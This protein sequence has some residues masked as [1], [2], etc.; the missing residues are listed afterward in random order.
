MPD[1]AGGTYPGEFLFTF[2]VSYM[3]LSTSMIWFRRAKD[4]CDSP[5]RCGGIWE[6]GRKCLVPGG[7]YHI[8][9]SPSFSEITTCTYTFKHSLFN[10]PRIAEIDHRFLKISL[11]CHHVAYQLSV[12][13]PAGGETPPSPVHVLFNTR[14]GIPLPSLLFHSVPIFW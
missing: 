11:C 12:S 13:T 10:A 5:S 1:L 7:G 3:H 2:Y 6:R 4:R 8:S 9:V 14:R